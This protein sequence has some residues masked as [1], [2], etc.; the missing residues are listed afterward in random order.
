MR[1]SPAAMNW[2]F[3]SEEKPRLAIKG[4]PP[5]ETIQIVRRCQTHS[6]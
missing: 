4:S 1:G 5:A 6:F 2:D 3:Q